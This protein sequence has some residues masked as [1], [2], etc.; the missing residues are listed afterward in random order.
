MQLP[1]CHAPHPHP[2]RRG[3]PRSAEIARWE[4]GSQAGHCW[5]PWID[6][7]L[8][9][10][11]LRPQARDAL[12]HMLR[13]TFFKRRRW[14]QGWEK[15]GSRNRGA[16]L[17]ECWAGRKKGISSCWTVWLFFVLTSSLH[18][19]LWWPCLPGLLPFSLISVSSL[20]RPHHPSKLPL[21]I[22]L[23]LQRTPP[24]SATHSHVL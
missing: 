1:R 13:G 3:W 22:P 7:P 5:P 20:I 10:Y 18:C 17:K 15:R 4:L 19:S 11:I 14:G 8:G 6:I 12:V 21:M 2:L 9:S 24:E 16:D 23:C